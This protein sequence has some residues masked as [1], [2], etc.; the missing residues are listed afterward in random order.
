MGP[1]YGAGRY[2]PAG[3]GWLRISDLTGIP[4][5]PKG[6]CEGV[7]VV[8]PLVNQVHAFAATLVV[9]MAASF[10]Y[11]Y[12]RVV[13]RLFKLRK[14]GTCLGDAVFWLIT[15]ALVFFLLLLVN[16][17]VVRFY[18]FLALS[19]G[20]IIYFQLFSGLAR[21][22]LNLKFYLFYHLWKLAIKVTLFIWQAV[23]F[24]VRLVVTILFYPFYVFRKLFT[25]AG[26]WL[27]RALYDLV[28]RRVAQ[29]IKKAKPK[30]ISL[31]FW[32]KRKN[33]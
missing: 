16:W 9:G 27:Q 10:C 4:A 12:Y 3:R 6:R 22:L 32:Q 13:R 24:P 17:G 31:A 2:V 5:L 30:L 28:G 25:S 11:D 29:G 20:A 14:I 33:N 23:F 19:L 7:S 18:V 1:A 26:H 15:T 8:E 21:R